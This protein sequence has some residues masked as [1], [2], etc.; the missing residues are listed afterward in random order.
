MSTLTS[1]CHV[2]GSHSWRKDSGKIVLALLLLGGACLD[3]PQVYGDVTPRS[4]A[5]AERSPAAPHPNENLPPQV[6][7]PVQASG[8]DAATAGDRALANPAVGLDLSDVPVFSEPGLPIDLGYLFHLMENLNDVAEPA[9]Q[10]A[11]DTLRARPAESVQRLQ[12]LYHAT[13]RSWYLARWKTVAALGALET[14]HATA[15]LADIAA[16]PI[17]VEQAHVDAVT[18]DSSAREEEGMIRRSAIHG[19]SRLVQRGEVSALQSLAQL[20]QAEDR[21][22]VIA[23]ALELHIQGKLTKAQK[24]SLRQRGIA[25]NFTKIPS[26]QLYR[27]P[28]AELEAAMDKQRHRKSTQ[29]PQ[30]D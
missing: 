2:H 7:S 23:A 20:L 16:A 5:V 26:E 28:Q 25:A 19:L 18:H 27:I 14:P 15:V 8:S 29:P 22:V 3:H 11:L 4:A 30:L 24:T 6:T 12:D 13:P 17:V 21:E 10:R 1:L 9:Y